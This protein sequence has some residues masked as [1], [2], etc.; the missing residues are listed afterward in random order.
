VHRL[1]YCAARRPGRR[2]QIAGRTT[3][4]RIRTTASAA[5]TVGTDGIDPKA[6]MK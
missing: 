3:P 2:D 5:T 1:R 4:Q 6:R